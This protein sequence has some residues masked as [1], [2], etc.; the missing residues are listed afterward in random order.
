M[1]RPRFFS[2][3]Q[4]IRSR[5]GSL[6]IS[7]ERLIPNAVQVGPQRIHSSRVNLIET[8]RSL[9]PA[10]DEPAIF[11]QAKVLGYRRPGDWELLGQFSHGPGVLSQQL[12]DGAAASITE[13]A[14]ARISVSGH[15]RL[16]YAYRCARSCGIPRATTTRV[17]AQRNPGAVSKVEAAGIDRSSRRSPG[18]IGCC[19][20]TRCG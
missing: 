19:A 9:R 2:Y 11:E 13:Q 4:V 20:P 8:A 16:V 1:C 10:E 18:Y 15:E 5:L 3:L 14:Q 6:L 12:E 7:S 17:R